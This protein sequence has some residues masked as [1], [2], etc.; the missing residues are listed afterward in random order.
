MRRL[1]ALLGV[2]ASAIY[3]HFPNKQAL[4][5]EVADRILAGHGPGSAAEPWQER[6][7]GEAAAIRD[8]LLEHRDSAE[9]VVS[10]MALGLGSDRALVRLTAALE[11]GPFTADDTRRAAAVVLHFVLGHVSLEQQ[12][13]WY[14]RLGA[15]DGHLVMLRDLSSVDD[16]RFGIRTVVLG[17]SSINSQ[18]SR[19]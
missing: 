9:I 18:Q 4:L 12:R 14:D 19:Q 7:R 15:R 10:T 3:W 16:F 1:A 5:A 13:L 11:A 8:A 17:L 6:V 2:Q